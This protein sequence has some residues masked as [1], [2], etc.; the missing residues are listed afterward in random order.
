[1]PCKECLTR[2]QI[3]DC[4]T[5]H[6]KDAKFSDVKPDECLPKREIPND[7][8]NPSC[9]LL[10]KNKCPKENNFNKYTFFR[11]AFCGI[12]VGLGTYYF[13]RNNKK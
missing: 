2:K 11:L 12:G 3:K 5:S 9:N 10:K 8:S 13:Y 4:Q 1:M 6:Y 7:R